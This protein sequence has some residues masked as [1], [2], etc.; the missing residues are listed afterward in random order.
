MKKPL[1][2]TLDRVQVYC[3]QI[4]TG[5]ARTKGYGTTC[6]VL[7]IRRSAT[8][9]SLNSPHEVLRDFGHV[10][11]DYGTKRGHCARVLAEARAF[12]RMVSPPEPRT[13]RDEF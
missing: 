8:F 13:T 11:M 10:R 7:V 1:D 5:T 12:A 9:R 3:P 4:P 6:R 2:R